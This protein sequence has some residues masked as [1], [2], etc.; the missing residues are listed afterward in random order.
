ME[1]KS[2]TIRQTTTWQTAIRQM[3]IGVVCTLLLWATCEVV[4]FAQPVEARVASING[5]VIRLNRTTRFTVRRGDVLSPGDELDTRGG[6]RVTIQLTDG[7]LIV[8]QPGSHVILKDFRAA[9]SL[10][11][12]VQVVVG[13]IRVK[14]AHYGGRPNPYRVNSPTASILV[15]GTEFAVT[16]DAS[17]E[18]GVLVYEGLVEVE[19]LSDPNRRALLTPGN[20]ALIRPNEDL[21][22]FTPGSRESDERGLRIS[23]NHQHML[24]PNGP[25]N[26][27]ALVSGTA[28][29]YIAGTYERYIDS[30]VEPGESAP[31]MRF[32]AFADS[33]LDSLENPSYA[34]EFGR[35]ESRSL[36]ISSFSDSSAQFKGRQQE[37]FFKSVEPL[38]TG[39]LAQSTVFLPLPNTRWVL[40]GSFASSDSS[41][42]NTLRQ[43]SKGEPSLFYPRG[44][45]YRRT[46]NSETRANSQSASLM[47][48]RSLGQEG[49]TSVGIGIDYL[50]GNGT[51]RGETSLAHFANDSKIP[52]FRANESLHAE[53]DIHRTRLKLGL[54]HQ[55]SG[56]HKLGIVYRHGLLSAQDQDVSRAFNGLPLALDSITYAS[57]SNELGLRWR[58]P[59]TRKLFYGVEG[60]WLT[61]G[62]RENINRAIA[63]EVIERERITRASAS[64][65]VGYALTRQT[66]FSADVA[67]GQSTILEDY[68]EHATGNPIEQERARRRF[69]SAQIGVQS[70][71]WKNLFGS[72]SVLRIAQSHTENRQLFPDR[73]GRLLDANGLPASIGLERDQF[74]DNYADFGF[75]WRVTKNILAQYIL[76]TSLGR[77]SPNHIFLLRY[78]LRKD[79]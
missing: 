21:R 46:S 58:G 8:I 61:T 14:I 42:N 72:V 28:R 40:G 11:E 45:T 52:I 55:F 71:L 70:D 24:T 16:V 43:T 64:F 32:T 31:V 77:Q 30:L 33:H 26:L 9:A 53:S 44:T 5:N 3:T 10:R 20:G 50:S 68:Y 36:I 4:A 76:A 65:G 38:N 60:H 2:A 48:A 34:T 69:V 13:R 6:G 19:S 27:G 79:E 75:G 1:G 73:F 51:L 62:I 22:F 7:S 78:T 67:A 41:V 17:G 39:W 57:Q 35:F 66:V 15:R 23:D 18:T 63:V 59:L 29:S 25:G 56:N 12:L 74:S 37:N 54:T 49:R 47:L